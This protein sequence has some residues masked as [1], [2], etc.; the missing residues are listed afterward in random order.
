MKADS[1]IVTLMLGVSASANEYLATVPCCAR[2]PD[3]L[4]A[5]GVNGNGNGSQLVVCTHIPV[6][7]L[8]YYDIHHRSS[9]SSF[10]YT[11]YRANL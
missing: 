1:V 11:R 2:C 4:A 5:T 10:M 6:L 7:F 8:R 3:G 9:G